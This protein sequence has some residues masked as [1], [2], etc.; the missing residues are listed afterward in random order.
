MSQRPT[1][2]GKPHA[3]RFRKK[4]DKDLAL[5][6]V[7]NETKVSRVIQVAVECFL[8]NTDC[9]ARKEVMRSL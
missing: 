8:R 9:L 2:Y 4:I 5:F 3:V 7:E 1:E 6:C